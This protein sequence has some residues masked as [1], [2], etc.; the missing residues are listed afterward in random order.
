M[1]TVRS[2]GIEM[3]Y[4]MQGSGAP[5]LL[6]AGYGCDHTIWSK[7]ASTLTGHFRVIVFD[8]RGLGR[9]SGEA[10]TS[11]Q[12]MAEDA[13]GL[14]DALRPGPVHVA[15]HSMGGM[16]AQELV[17]AHPDKVR[18]LILLSSSARLDARGRAIIESWGDL[19][20]LLAAETLTRL[21]LPWIYT[22][23]YYARPGA[24]DQVVHEILA[25][26][27]PPTPQC[28]YAQSRGISRC[29]THDRLGAIGCPTMV[30]IGSEDILAPVRFS[31][32]LAQ[33]IR[34]AELVVREKTGHGML[35]ETPGA[36]A[37]VML[38][39]L[40]QLERKPGR[41]RSLGVDDAAKLL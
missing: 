26:P 30:T 23:A 31:Q 14:L 34:G 20:R 8:N 13:A 19:P 24:I 21:V 22:N 15:G 33:G 17:L 39:F 11:I 12:E 6:I 1:A 28:L 27:S 5:L 3:Y 37:S 4:E 35:I 25:N 16:I 7:V 36:V 38:Q 10:A 32:E 18:S 40:A 2:N 9:S 41:P 29:D